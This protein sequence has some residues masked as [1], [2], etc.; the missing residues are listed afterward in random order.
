[1]TKRRLGSESCCEGQVEWR[2]RN[3]VAIFHHLALLLGAHVAYAGTLSDK[4]VERAEQE[5][6]VA[7]VQQLKVGRL[8]ERRVVLAVVAAQV[9]NHVIIVATKPV[10]RGRGDEQPD[11]GIERLRCLAHRRHVVR[12]M[13]DDVEQKGAIPLRLPAQVHQIDLV[14]GDAAWQCISRHVQRSL[15][16]I[17]KRQRAELRRPPIREITHPS[18]YPPPDPQQTKGDSRTADS[19]RVP[20]AGS[21]V[22]RGT[23]NAFPALP[24]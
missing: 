5:H 12:Q 8:G 4:P 13:F 16:G 2:A 24:R 1:M 3:L 15:G 19:D 23:R 17:R 22:G 6:E 18:A 7:G 11:A 14:A 9:M 21:D 10:Q 20:R